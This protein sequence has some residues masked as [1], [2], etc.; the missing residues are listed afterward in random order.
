MDG[1]AF[2]PAGGDSREVP[3]KFELEIGDVRNEEN[4]PSSSSL[5]RRTFVA[6]IVTVFSEL[7]S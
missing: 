4:S 1:R 5:Q 3:V 7:W 6:G 2:A